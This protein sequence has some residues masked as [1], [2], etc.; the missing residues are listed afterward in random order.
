MI[1]TGL[2]WRGKKFT[3]GAKYSMIYFSK[4]FLTQKRNERKEDNKILVF[5]S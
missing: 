5:S 2:N 3:A 1:R 4:E